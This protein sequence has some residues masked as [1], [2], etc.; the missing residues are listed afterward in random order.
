MSQSWTPAHCAA[1]T[2]QMKV[3]KILNEYAADL[4]MIDEN[5][6]TPKK[7]AQLYGHIGCVKYLQSK[8]C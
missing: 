3:L 6:D 1:E 7:I 5:G 2:G 4:S 8:D